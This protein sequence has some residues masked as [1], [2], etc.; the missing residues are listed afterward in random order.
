MADNNEELMSMDDLDHVAGGNYN[1][2]LKDLR[3][4]AAIGLITNDQVP[5][6]VDA[7]NFSAMN[8]L[9]FETWQKVG[10]TMQGHEGVTN[11]YTLPTTATATGAYTNDRSGALNYAKYQSGRGDLDISAYL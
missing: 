10:V 2:I 8:R 6:N 4:F 3:A 5:A 1:E 11:S 9:A 7:S